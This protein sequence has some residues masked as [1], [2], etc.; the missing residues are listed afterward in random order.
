ME[1]FIKVKKAAEIYG[2]GKNLL[3]EAIRT[4]EL[5]AYKPNG[6]DFL[7]KASELEDWIESHPT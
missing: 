5:K 6:R 2:I 3:Y 1:N 7:I 4:K